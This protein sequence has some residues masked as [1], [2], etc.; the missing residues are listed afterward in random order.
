[1]SAVQGCALTGTRPF[2]QVYMHQAMVA[3]EGEKMSKS[4]G[5]LVLVSALRAAGVDPMVI[6][7]ALLDHHYRTEWESTRPGRRWWS[8]VNCSSAK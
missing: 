5:N 6:R 7:L 2:A 4:K 1:M 8:G 3:F